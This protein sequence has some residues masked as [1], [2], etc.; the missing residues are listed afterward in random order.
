[1][2]D[3]KILDNIKALDGGELGRL[4]RIASVSH[5]AEEIFGDV[6]AA[7]EWM[8]RPNTALGAKVPF[9]LCETEFGAKQVRLVLH[10]LESGGVA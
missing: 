1:M 8:A 7:A 10:A 6:S 4:D 5:Q 2:D 3:E 9:Q